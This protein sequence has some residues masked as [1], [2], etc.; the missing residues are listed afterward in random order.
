MRANLDIE[1]R[2]M[3]TKKF[4]SHIKTTNKSTR[5]PEVV[6]CSAL[7]TSDPTTKANLF[8]DY[9]RK[10]FSEPSNYD[11]DINFQ[12]DCNFDVD[13]SV[14]KIKLILN[15]LDINKAQGPDNING[16]SSIVLSR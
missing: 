16:S 1:N 8:N 5:K 13:L 6:S 14:S 4:W 9:F 10:Q 2:N 7:A 12:N 3:L 11:I 15:N